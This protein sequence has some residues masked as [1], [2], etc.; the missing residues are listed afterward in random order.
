MYYI[1]YFQRALIVYMCSL[2]KSPERFLALPAYALKM[3]SVTSSKVGELYAPESTHLDIDDVFKGESPCILDYIMTAHD[4]AFDEPEYLMIVVKTGARQTETGW[5]CD[6]ERKVKAIML[7]DEE[8]KKV[9]P[10][11]TAAEP[12]MDKPD[13]TCALP[14]ESK[15]A[16]DL[17]TDFAEDDFDEIATSLWDESSKP[18][19]LSE[20]GDSPDAKELRQTFM[21]NEDDRKDRTKEMKAVIDDTRYV[22]YTSKRLNQMTVRWR[23]RE[24]REHRS[25]HVEAVR[26]LKNMPNA[27]TM[28]ASR[29]SNVAKHTLPEC[30]KRAQ[31]WQN[32]HSARG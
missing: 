25:K 2:M 21:I 24:M 23:D 1:T 20:G 10:G 22:V 29:T 6:Y 5:V 26:T 27:K 4:G 3:Y 11:V 15:D 18:E 7:I 19:S 9:P 28:H 31:E 8:K 17:L 13:D 14:T 32:W 12:V 30:I 16:D